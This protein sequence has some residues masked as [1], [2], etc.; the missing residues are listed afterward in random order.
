MIGEKSCASSVTSST[1]NECPLDKKTKN[2]SDRRSE[3]KIAC[4]QRTGSQDTEKWLPILPTQRK[5]LFST[6]GALFRS[7]CCCRSF[8]KRKAIELHRIKKDGTTTKETLQLLELIGIGSFKKVFLAKKGK[9]KSV[10]CAFAYGN[11]QRGIKSFL[12]E[13]KIARLL[14]KHRVP[15]ALSIKIGSFFDDKG[16]QAVA[17]YMTFCSEGSLFNYGNLEIPLITRLGLA[18]DVAEWLAHVHDLGLAHNDI[19]IENIFVSK[20][21]DGSLEAFVGDYEGIHACDR[22]RKHFLPTTFPPPEVQKDPLM[23]SVPTNDLWGLGDILAKLIYGE[24]FFYTRDCDC[25]TPPDNFQTK[26]A[27]LHK[28]IQEKAQKTGDPLD[29]CIADL[30]SLDPTKRPSAQQVVALIN[31]RI[32]KE[33]S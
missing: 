10:A 26:V 30:F 4:S 7:L 1:T 8:R 28:D 32:K 31:Q 14:K 18:R 24:S 6:I 29:Q 22:T 19:K 17:T 5:G 12:H 3:N 16:K 2:S 9:N 11:Q 23:P 20:R 15:H 21:E 27:Q 25:D 33:S 13:H